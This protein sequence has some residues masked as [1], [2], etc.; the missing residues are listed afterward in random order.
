MND[1]VCARLHSGTRSDY[2][3]THPFSSLDS[4]SAINENIIIII[5]FIRVKVLI[6]PQDTPGFILVL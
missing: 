2:L 6:F 5:L 4:V 3:R 1:P